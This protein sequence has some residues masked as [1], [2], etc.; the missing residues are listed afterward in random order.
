VDPT[1]N[2]ALGF[3]AGVS[4]AGPLEKQFFEIYFP[5]IALFIFYLLSVWPCRFAPLVHS[6]PGLSAYAIRVAAKETRKMTT[7]MVQDWDWDCDW[8]W[9]WE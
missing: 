3:G 1:S 7:W 9:E 2:R 4:F 8:E 6:S 5:F